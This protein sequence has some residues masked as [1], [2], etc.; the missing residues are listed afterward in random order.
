MQTTFMQHLLAAPL[1]NI[2]SLKFQISRNG[3]EFLTRHDQLD[4]QQQVRRISSASL[5]S[6][7]NRWWTQSL[8]A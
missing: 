7:R 6:A 5:L 2:L 1:G 8:S 3:C 4:R